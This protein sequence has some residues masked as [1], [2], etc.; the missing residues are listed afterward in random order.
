MAVLVL[1]L[2]A[3]GSGEYAREMLRKPYV[4]GEYMFS[5]GVR[6]NQIANL[7]AS[8]YLASS[9]CTGPGATSRLARGEAIYRGECG[10]CHTRDGYRSLKR[11][12]AAR[13]RDSSARY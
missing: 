10:A 1:A 7:D 3:T 2:V 12:L 9:I 8:G 5:N 4:V 6:V 11:L 13:D